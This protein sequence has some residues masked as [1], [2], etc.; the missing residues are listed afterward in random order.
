M[1]RAVENGGR[2]AEATIIPN[3]IIKGILVH[4][5]NLGFFLR[6]K[7]KWRILKEM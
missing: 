4:N 2:I 5:K 1:T 6:L 7:S 3:S